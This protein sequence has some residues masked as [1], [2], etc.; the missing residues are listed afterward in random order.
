M[1]RLTRYV[2][3]CLCLLGAGL[4][5]NGCNYSPPHADFAQLWG[6]LGAGVF[7]TLKN[8]ESVEYYKVAAALPGPG[9]QSYPPIDKVRKLSDEQKTELQKLL[10][11]DNHYLFGILKKCVFIP[12]MAFHFKKGGKDVLMLVS[13]SCKQVVYD[14]GEQQIHLDIDPSVDSFSDFIHH[15]PN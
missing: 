8:P 4:S 5:V 11:N 14:L 1:T 15:L 9:K 6:V 2:F 13:L 12:E 10:L 7:D 3:I